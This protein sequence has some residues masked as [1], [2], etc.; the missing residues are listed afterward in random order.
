MASIRIIALVLLSTCA[1]A[2]TFAEWFSQRKTQKKYLLAQIEAL[3][4]YGGFLKKGYTIA[5]GGLGSITN[6]IGD[7]FQLHTAYYDRL[8]NADPS[9]KKNSQ[10]K[11]IIGWQQDIIKQT[12]SWLADD[13]AYVTK[14]KTALLQDCEAQLT[15]LTNV[16][17]GGTEMSDAERLQQIEILHAA[18]L[19]NLHF[20]TNFSDQLKRFNIQKQQDL[21]STNTL[22][23]LY[24]NH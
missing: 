11:Q 17:S 2:Q 18:M 8:K 16:I 12:N 14:V 13:M 5:K 21:N 22:K 19:S 24:A 7:E 1:K 23:G 4:V 15:E 20:A 6:Y 9:L 10:V 3:Q